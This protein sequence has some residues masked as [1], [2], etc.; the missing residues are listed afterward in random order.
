MVFLVAADGMRPPEM[1]SNH[2][3]ETLDSPAM[4]FHGSLLSALSF[5]RRSPR[6]CWAAS[7][8][9]AGGLG[10]SGLAAPGSCSSRGFSSSFRRGS[11]CDLPS[12]IILYFRFCLAGL[13]V[14]RLSAGGCKSWT[15]RARSSS[16]S[17]SKSRLMWLQ[18]LTGT[19]H[20][21]KKSGNAFCP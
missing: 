14:S 2:R 15:P 20:R 21:R 6:R 5:F 13:L 19:Q 18:A 1:S 17:C 7:S 4:V 11:D 8:L 3:Y 10:P 12:P 16:S 9:I